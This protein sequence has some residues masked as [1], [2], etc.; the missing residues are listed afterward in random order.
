[1]LIALARMLPGFASW[2]IVLAFFITALVQPVFAAFLAIYFIIYCTVRGFWMVGAVVMTWRKMQQQTNCN[3]FSRCKML[4]H[5]HRIHHLV[6]IPTYKEGWDIL[7]KTFLHL[8][9]SNY[10]LRQISICLA[11]EAKDEDA[12]V[13][14]AQLQ[15]AYGDAFAHFFVTT[16]TLAPGEAVGKGSNQAAAFRTI[17]PQ[18]EQEGYSKDQV[19]VTS[20]DADYCVHP[21]YFGVLSY[22]YITQAH[23][24]TRFFQP[25]PLFFN[26][27]WQA[28]F[29]TR[30]TSTF[31]LQA[32][33]WMYTLTDDLVNFS[34]YALSWKL[35]DRAG[36]WDAQVIQEDSRL[37]WRA[38]FASGGE[39][40]V[41]P[42][43]I[44]MYGHPVVD[45]TLWET[46]RS[47]YRQ[48][49]RWA[50][51]VT[52]FPYLV[53]N[54][55]QHREINPFLRLKSLLWLFFNHLNWATLPVFLFFGTGFIPLINPAFS[56]TVLSHNLAYFSGKITILAL[57]F[58]VSFIVTSELLLFPPKPSH[59]SWWR[60]AGTLGHWLVFPIMGIVFGALPAFD[61]QTRALLGKT[62]VYTVSPKGNTR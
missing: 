28:P 51:G 52:D 39:S 60:R 42:L 45:T 6:I 38:F 49:K 61:S 20:L 11:T 56:N 30:V 18:L 3:W 43:H 40:R 16:H 31:M 24:D 44:P 13:H 55:I 46:L 4:P 54:C 58:L 25:I 57:V 7:S 37:Y 35:L 14:A 10:P 59:W 12:R 19:I 8:A 17:A 27:I 15:E 62:I 29:F 23:A 48:L 47:Q 5:W 50:W 9:S 26:A 34:C 2:A 36:L 41:V 32:F 22:H 21:E 53:T 1:M 33:M